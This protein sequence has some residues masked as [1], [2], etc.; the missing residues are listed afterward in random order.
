MPQTTNSNQTGRSEQRRMPHLCGVRFDLDD[1][2]A[3]AERLA[4]PKCE[5]RENNEDRRH[6]ED[7]STNGERIAA[8]APRGLTIGNCKRKV[9]KAEDI[10]A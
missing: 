9:G 5:R 1:D 2:G 6:K 8:G 4:P 3:R 7:L 10:A